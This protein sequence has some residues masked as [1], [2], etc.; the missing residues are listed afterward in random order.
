VHSGLCWIRIPDDSSS[1]QERLSLLF[2]AVMMFCM[3]PFGWQAFP[4]AEKR[5]FVLDSAKDL[6]SPSAYFAAYVLSS[7]LHI[8]TRV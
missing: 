6:Y 7:T 3:I 2:F 4:L 5:F 1:A 8:K